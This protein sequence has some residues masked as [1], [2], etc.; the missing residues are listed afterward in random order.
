MKR[1]FTDILKLFGILV[2]LIVAG[3]LLLVAAYALPTQGS[4]R[5]HALR[6]AEIVY[7]TMQITSE[8]AGGK[9]DNISDALMMLT[10]TCPSSGNVFVDALKCP[11]ESNGDYADLYLYKLA[12]GEITDSQVIPLDRYWQGYLVFLKPLLL[13]IGFDKIRYFNAILIGGLFIGL[14]YLWQKNGKQ[15]YWIPACMMMA[16]FNPVSVVL[17]MCFIGSIINVLVQLIVMEA[18]LD[19]YKKHPFAVLAHFLAFGALTSYT[20][21]LTFPVVTIGIPLIYWIA[22]SREEKPLVNAIVNSAV[23]S[24]GY[25]GMWAGKWVLGSLITGENMIAGALG[26]ISYRVG[27]KAFDSADSI[28]YSRLQVLMAQV[29]FSW[30][31]LFI[32]GL[33]FVVFLI[34][35]LGNKKLTGFKN[36]QQ[37]LALVMVCLYPIAWYMLV[38][39][40]SYIHS[41]M[42]Y[43]N[44]A[45]TVFGAFVIL[46]VQGA[47]HD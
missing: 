43:R 20:E 8:S 45:V 1:V 30:F 7:P 3:Y 42:T 11:Q 37:L 41:W 24:F 14:L 22:E 19:Y 38:V 39:N 28:K 9:L 31:A 32:I 44:L 17:S 21:Y 16:F 34:Y 13:C 35:L 36:K 2:C 46:S 27:D 5:T 23:W 12:K 29:K 47:E 15:H 26:V 18:N 40:H 25:L 33:I 10:A 6:A 4:M